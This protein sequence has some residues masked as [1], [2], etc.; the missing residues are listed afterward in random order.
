MAQTNAAAPGTAGTAGVIARP[1]VIYLGFLVL[2]LAAEWWWPLGLPVDP[3]PDLRRGLAIALALAGAGLVWRAF[4]RFTRAGT[5]VQTW[6]PTLAIVTDG[7]YGYSRNPIYVGM[8]AI[9]LGVAMGV[10]SPWAL[11]LLVPT[12]LL[13]QFGVIAREERYLEGKFGPA[14]VDYRARVR[15]WL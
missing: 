14:Y 11:A 6:K 13:M 9:Y 4:R 3:A 10:G 2:G 8:T 1:P 12:L 7:L 5:N 15:R